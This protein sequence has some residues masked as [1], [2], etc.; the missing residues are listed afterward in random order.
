MS[1]KPAVD[2]KKQDRIK[3]IIKDRD[4]HIRRVLRSKSGTTIDAPA[5]TP[6]PEVYKPKDVFTILWAIGF[7]CVP[8]VLHFSMEL[9]NPESVNLKGIISFLIIYTG[10]VVAGHA[11]L[12]GS[13]DIV[14]LS[15]AISCIVPV[16]LTFLLL[17]FVPGLTLPFD[18]TIGYFVV[19]YF[20]K[21]ISDPMSK[22]ESSMFTKDALKKFGEDVKVPFDWLLTTFN[23]TR[24]A[25]L[26]EGLK[27]ISRD[28]L[29]PKWS[30]SVGSG[31]IL[32]FYININTKDEVEYDKFVV[33]LW[34]M[35]ETKHSTGHFLMIFMACVAGL[36]MS[37]G[38]VLNI[39]PLKK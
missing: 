9:G 38:I 15:S 37:L 13:R 12:L 21:P 22:F 24:K 18:N 17:F 7:V 31:T 1:Q 5:P 35:I 10:L 20:K 32:D 4:E 39:T 8:L 36:A 34:S 6:V 23:F 29:S 25:D 2:A 11:Q 27:S 30:E 33:D 26:K 19:K 16:G 14:K 28:S 3:K